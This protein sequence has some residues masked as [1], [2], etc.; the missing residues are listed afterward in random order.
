VALYVSRGT[1]RRRTVIAVVVAA[2][3][4]FGIGLL[5]GR[6]MTSSID[7]RVDS[8][9]NSAD[10]VATAIERL[11]IEYAQVLDGTDVLQ[12]AVLTPIDDLREQLQSTMER[13]PW[14]VADQRSTMLD[15]I[16]Q[17]SSSANAHD[18]AETFDAHLADAAKAVR[19]AFGVNP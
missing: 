1:R 8:V 6:Q 5:I 4:A 18:P 7:E 11:D 3:V 14:L 12:T 19:T 16:A 2:L 9:R 13:A 17:L 15:A 10:Q